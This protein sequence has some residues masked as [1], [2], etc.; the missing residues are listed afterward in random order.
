MRVSKETPSAPEAIDNAYAARKL[1]F[2]ENVILTI[3]VLGVAGFLIAA[4]W[5][6]TLWTAA[7]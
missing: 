7:E 4:L 1:T 2:R 3:K 6:L 5:G